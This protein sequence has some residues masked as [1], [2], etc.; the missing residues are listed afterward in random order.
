M[1]NFLC[2]T[3]R[4]DGL[5]EERARENAAIR[6]QAVQRG[7]Q[8]RQEVAARRKDIEAYKAAAAN[9]GAA[10][11]DLGEGDANVGPSRL[12]QIDILS[13]KNLRNCIRGM[14]SRNKSSPFVKC[15]VGGVS[16]HTATIKSNLNPV[17][18]E[19]F[20]VA[21][22]SPGTEI[23]LA[24]YHPAVKKTPEILLGKVTIPGDI[25][26]GEEQE[27]TLEETGLKKGKS[28][29]KVKVGWA[30]RRAEKRISAYKD[31]PV[32]TWIVRYR[33][34]GLRRG[35][36][37]GEQRA[38]VDLQPGEEFGVI[39]V[40]E[41]AGGQ[42]YLRL[43]DGRGWAFTKSAKDNELLCERMEIKEEPVIEDEGAADA[44]AEGAEG[45]EGAAFEE[46]GQPG[47]EPFA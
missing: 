16:F 33:A 44:G 12:L 41:G 3:E 45:A 21:D 9:G 34:I 20:E 27:Y 37:I 46:A 29:L 15:D 26:E 22:Y 11:E 32:E 25:G 40:V 13:A 1:F 7:K 23:T 19:S 4:D 36:G 6:I 10:R 31:A 43:A 8:G 5:S 35:P 30:A 24:V 38:G 17:W 42:E 47:E 14:L 2:C 18:N 39:E 28:L